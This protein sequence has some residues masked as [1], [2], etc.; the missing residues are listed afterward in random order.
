MS[1]SLQAAIDYFR[2]EAFS[3]LFLSFKEKIE[4]HGGVGGTVTLT[5][6]SESECK[7]ILRFMG[8]V[9]KKQKSLS[10][11]L[12]KFEKCFDETKFEGLQL[13]TVVSHVLKTTIFYKKDRLE[14]EEE[15]KKTFFL[16]LKE[17]HQHPYTDYLT[18]AIL[19]KEKGFSSFIQAY[20]ND[21]LQS[22]KAI[23]KALTLINP[24]SFIRL[25]V[26]ATKATGDPH[27]FDKE[28]KLITALE[29]IHSN[30]TNEPYRPNLN[31]QE[32]SELLLIFGIMKDDLSSFSTCNGLIAESNGE[33][34]KS[35]AYA[36]LE[37]RDQNI[38]MRQLATIDAIYPEKGKNVFV[39]ENAGVYSSIMDQSDVSLP[40]ICTHGQ[41]K[42]AGLML[43]DKLAQS[44]CT[45]YYSGDFDINGLSMAYALKKRLQERLLFWRFT[46]DSYRYSLSH[47]DLKQ[48][49]LKQLD[50]IDD[51]RLIPLINA[52]K[53]TKKAGY[54]EQL[55]E[56]L[57][58]DIISS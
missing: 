26:F 19:T 7:K 44:G 5:K 20:N 47:V 24:K 30:E 41:F 25:P 12:S 56:D 37:N 29:M 22:I 58:Q 3:R 49:R 23:Y 50:K 6:P 43:L 48:T 21:E 14:A 1:D 8:K 35:W 57:Y 42:L 36:C 32:V 2:Q 38:N 18:H 13:E 31:A 27:A 39:V 55:I 4:Q 17:D 54:Q 40:L 16:R 28:T 51:K 10:V 33:V 46:V 53:E 34:L 52:M 45:I 9:P 15:T 11:S